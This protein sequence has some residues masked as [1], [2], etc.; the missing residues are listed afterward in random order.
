MMDACRIADATQTMFVEVKATN[1]KQES[2]M[3]PAL[4]ADFV[5]LPGRQE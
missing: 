2:S 4:K 3:I 5:R 1:S